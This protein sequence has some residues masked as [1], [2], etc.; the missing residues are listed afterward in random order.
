MAH[1]NNLVKANKHQRAVQTQVLEGITSTTD[2]GFINTVARGSAIRI[3]PT[4]A[5]TATVYS[6]QRPTLKLNE[7]DN[8]HAEVTGST[9]RQW[10]AWGAGAVTALTTQQS[11]IPLE[12]AALTVASGTWSIEI[13][14]E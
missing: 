2:A 11:N 13:T 5:G 4:V 10:E 9:N 12:A 8:T 1:T 14:S 6:T 3:F 7:P